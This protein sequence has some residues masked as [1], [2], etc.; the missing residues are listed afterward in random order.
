MYETVDQARA[1]FRSV[2]AELAERGIMLPATITRYLTE[3]EK[4]SGMLAFEAV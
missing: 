2:R 1:A 3:G 4:R